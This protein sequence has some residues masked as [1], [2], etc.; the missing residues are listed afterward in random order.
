MRATTVG[1]EGGGGP[2]PLTF[3]TLVFDTQLMGPSTSKLLENAEFKNEFA[4]FSRDF[5]PDPC[6]SDATFMGAASLISQ[7]T[8][9][10]KLKFLKL[11]GTHRVH[12]H[13]VLLYANLNSNLDL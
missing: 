7:Q 4:Q 11:E 1:T 12:T 9:A 2:V 13:A 5:T 8:F 6:P 3:E 10:V